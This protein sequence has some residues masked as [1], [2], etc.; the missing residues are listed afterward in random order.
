MTIFNLYNTATKKRTMLSARNFNQA[1]SEVKNMLK[2]DTL[3]ANLAYS[4]GGFKIYELSFENYL[5]EEEN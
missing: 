1:M 4:V 3:S 5:I 2:A